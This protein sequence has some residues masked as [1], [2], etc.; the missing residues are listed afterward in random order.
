MLN[1]CDA[2]TL[3]FFSAAG[4]M[5]SAFSEN[6]NRAIVLAEIEFRIPAERTP[7]G[8]SKYKNFRDGVTPHHDNV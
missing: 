5:Q 2:V 4:K 3:F 7:P 8:G 6:G 1:W